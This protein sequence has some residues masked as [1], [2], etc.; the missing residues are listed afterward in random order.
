MKYFNPI[1]LSID[2]TK[3]NNTELMDDLTSI[4][5]SLIKAEEYINLLATIIIEQNRGTKA[6]IGT[7]ANKF[8]LE[9][10]ATININHLKSWRDTL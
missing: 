4:R 9:P 1:D 5:L 10:D 6:T 3:T 2:N 7:I 8:G